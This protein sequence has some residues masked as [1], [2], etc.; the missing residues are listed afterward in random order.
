MQ[1]ARQFCL[2]RAVGSVVT[3]QFFIGLRR[4]TPLS[5]ILLAIGFGATHGDAQAGTALHFGSTNALVQVA[6]NASL[7]SYPFTVTAWFRTTNGAAVVQGIVSK[8][9]DSS[10]NGWGLFVQNGRLRGFN[11]RNG[12]FVNLSIDAT[13]TAG[14][15]DGFWHHAA[16]T[17]DSTGG[18]LYLDGL[19]VGASSWTGAAGG[20]TT[21]QP[22]FMGR[23]SH[24]SYPSF[25]GDLDEITYWNRSLGTDEVNYLKHRQLNGNEDGLVGLWHFDEGTGL[26][27]ADATGH[28]HG[29]SLSNG[30]VWIESSAP[31]A[32]ASVAGTTVSLNGV[33]QSVTVSSTT[34]LNAYPLTVTAWVKTARTAFSYDG[35]VNKY[36]SGSGN[37]YSLHLYNGHLYAYYFRGDGAS[38]VYPTDPG[39]D[40]GVIADGQWHHLAF[41]VGGAGGK[42]FV[43][44]VQKSSLGWTGSPGPST[45]AA[46]LTIGQYPGFGTFAGQIDETSIWNR[47]LSL[48]ELQAMRNLRLSGSESNLVAYWRFDEGVNT[49]SV[50]LTGLGHLATLNN[51]PVWTGSTAFLGDGTSAIH[52]TLGVVQWSRR[53]A[54][55]TIP[56][57]SGFAASTPFWAR[58][59]DDFGAPGGNTSV[60]INLQ[61]ALQATLAGAVPL[62]NN[63]T[64]FNLSLPPYNAAAPQA[65]PGGI[66]QS[67]SLNLEPQAGTQLDSVN[68]LFQFGVAETYSINGGPVSDVETISLAA[69][70]LLHFNGHVFFGPIDTVLT[71][72]ANTPTRGT[73]T[74]PTH[75]LSRIL[76]P[77]PASTSAAVRDSA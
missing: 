8:Y 5:L 39:L 7:N 28:G 54:V 62:A 18:K 27:T 61:S 9:L 4:I 36:L 40:G 57:Q 24:S 21:T 23:Y 71:N 76:Q 1:L 13:S 58:R 17:V 67:P 11:Y 32:F 41:T 12:S 66:V 43:D 60:Q 51:G 31:L 45:T 44:G 46:A 6:H 77:R 33:N 64:Q 49:T 55:K 26:T 14:V 47:E 15:A 19:V 22:L 20:T 35:I 3:K 10:A 63:T 68:D 16:L 72:I 37:G 29:G 25:S 50:D 65:S 48:G 2:S 74:A 34:D 70:N 30:P 75:L 56:T 42:L 69:T 38:H 59:L 52:T 53:F 73:I